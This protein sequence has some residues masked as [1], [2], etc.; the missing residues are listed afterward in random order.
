MIGG[1]KRNVTSYGNGESTKT[2]PVPINDEKSNLPTASFNTEQNVRSKTMRASVFCNKDHFSDECH[3][4]ADVES[5]RIAAPKGGCCFKCLRKGHMVRDCHRA[6]ACFHCGKEGHH[7]ALCLRRE[8]PMNSRRE[9]HQLL[10]DNPVEHGE[11]ET[12]MVNELEVSTSPGTLTSTD[13][14]MEGVL[15]YQESNDDHI[16]MAMFPARA[17]NPETG[18]SVMKNVYL[19][20]VAKRTCIDAQ[21]AKQLHLKAKQELVLETSRFNT[22]K[23]ENV[24]AEYVELVLKG[25]NG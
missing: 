18:E 6:K 7:S 20:S 4:M 12:Q 24:N 8:K 15:T 2:K 10:D 11:E 25:Q 23:K 13:V 17:V 3:A 19:D 21:A 5:R 14:V 9:T 1:R 16:V 22:K